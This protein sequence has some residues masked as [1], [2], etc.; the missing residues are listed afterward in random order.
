MKA[1]LAIALVSAGALC[2]FGPA[3]ARS[4]G[5]HNSNSGTHASSQNKPAAAKQ[6]AKKKGKKDKETYLQYQMK[7]V[8]VSGAR[9]KKSKPK[10]SPITVNKKI[11]KSSP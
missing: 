1:N 3:Q 5:G 6:T 7:D 2:L 10:I 11:D 4:G 8:V 9:A